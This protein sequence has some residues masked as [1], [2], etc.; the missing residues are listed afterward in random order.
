V[1]AIGAL[2]L[3]ALRAHP[4]RVAFRYGEAELTYAEAER[5]VLTVADALAE[6]GLRPGDTVLQ[7]RPNDPLQWLVSAACYVAGHRSAALPPWTLRGAALA[8]RLDRVA[9]AAVLTE[10]GDDPDLDA[11][12]R[13]HPRVRV[14]TDRDLAAPRERRP[15]AR[16]A[17]HPEAVVRLAFTSGATGPA[18]G[19]E[20]TAGALGAVA[21]MLR[22]TLPWPDRPRVLCPEPVSGGFGNMVLPTLLL[23]G[24]F[25]IPDRPGAEALLDAA[26]RHRP[27]VLMAMPPMLRAMLHHPDAAACDWS[28]VELVVYS[29]AALT[30]DTIE[31]A[32]E[33]FGEVLCG[34]FGQVEAPK[35]IAWSPPADHRHPWLSASLGRPFPGTEVRVCG[36]GGR[37]L[38]PGRAGELWVRG[39]AIA[40]R[41][42]FPPGT[43][44]VDGWLRTGDVCR[45]DADGRL[46]HVDRIQ[47]VLRV[48]DAYVCPSDLE[49]AILRRTGRA[50][51]V[52][53]TGTASV[54][55]LVAT[56]E[57]GGRV[58]DPLDEAVREAVPEGVRE[59]LGATLPG[60]LAVPDAIAIDA[61]VSV[62]GLP[63]DAMGRLDRARLAAEVAR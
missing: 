20:L 24:T 49:A 63:R 32:H 14:L 17:A 57:Q 43:P 41:Y 18:K 25:L 26:A 2:V 15:T 12:L 9:P 39:P 5:L 42:A 50:A 8:E 3:D 4:D 19:V 6:S 7:I 60:L 55:V 29:G 28:S 37:D 56:G 40:R 46:F 22:D 59:A 23:G 44:V 54:T 36:P 13:A 10:P 1:T 21:T 30:I 45:R 34:V 58:Y 16:P 52:V 62:K 61:V 38:P 33:L 35:S 51:A 27:S 31:R 48:G 47:Y 11:W 53:P